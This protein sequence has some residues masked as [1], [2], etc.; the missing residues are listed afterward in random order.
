MLE[1]G[2]HWIIFVCL[3]VIPISVKQTEALPIGGTY[4]VF[5][6]GHN[7]LFLCY[8]FFDVVFGIKDPDVFT[9]PQE[10]M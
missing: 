3:S 6:I 2:F 4:H 7:I 9:P 8:S 1:S 10:C 5:V